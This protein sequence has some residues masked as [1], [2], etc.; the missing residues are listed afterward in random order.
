MMMMIIPRFFLEEISVS[1]LN[2]KKG[3]KLQG[4]LSESYYRLQ[5][6]YLGCPQFFHG[7]I[8]CDAFFS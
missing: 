3:K 1:S 2:F 5:R 7:K 4:C 6:K 8:F